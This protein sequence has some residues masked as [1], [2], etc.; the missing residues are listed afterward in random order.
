MHDFADAGMQQKSIIFA[1]L[2]VSYPV[3]LHI[4]THNYR[5][6]CVLCFLL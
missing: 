4:F 1:V 2:S 6:I 5:L 3:N